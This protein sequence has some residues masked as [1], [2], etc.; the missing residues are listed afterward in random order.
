MLG[1]QAQRAALQREVDEQISLENSFPSTQLSIDSVELED[2]DPS[3]VD[4]STT[5]SPKHSLSLCGS[6]RSP[7]RRHI[8]DVV[9]TQA[10]G[11][12]SGCLG[13]VKANK[14]RIPRADAIRSLETSFDDLL[15]EDSVD[16][17]ATSNMASG[18]IIPSLDGAADERP[19]YNPAQTKH[20][21]FSNLSPTPVEPDYTRFDEVSEDNIREPS[22]MPPG[23]VGNSDKDQTSQAEILIPDSAFYSQESV[24]PQKNDPAQ[25]RHRKHAYLAARGEDGRAWRTFSP[26]SAGN[27]HEVEI[28]LE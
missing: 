20:R 7:K 12:D 13:I 9:R 25:I 2:G 16:Y 21:R 17:A 24:E 11:A 23:A 15:E 8:S 27:A 26:I 4:A 3:L 22:A 10:R 19:S 28:E 1:L 14:E 5:E 18:V 6:S